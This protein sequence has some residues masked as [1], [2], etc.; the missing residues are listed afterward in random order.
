MYTLPHHVY[1]HFKNGA[2]VCNQSGLA[3]NCVALNEMHKMTSNSDCKMILAGGL[4][5]DILNTSLT[6]QFQAQLIDNFFEPTF[7][8]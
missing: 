6:R 3:L 5:S 7:P 8:K 4:P 2:F 1:N